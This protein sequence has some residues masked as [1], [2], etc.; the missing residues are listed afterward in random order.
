MNKSGGLKV[1]ISLALLASV[2]TTIVF[3]ITSG[4]PGFVAGII[5]SAFFIFGASGIFFGR[6][7]TGGL[8]GIFVWFIGVVIL[9]VTMFLCEMYIIDGGSK[10]G[11]V[12]G[13][14]G[15]YFADKVIDTLGMGM[16]WMFSFLSKPNEIPK[17]TPLLVFVFIFIFVIIG[18]LKNRNS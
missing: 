10:K 12:Y 3:T 1:F 8:G 9:L 11:K 6:G 7:L 4:I 2:I 18:K 15:D 14:G 13:P 16:D 5:T 17:Y